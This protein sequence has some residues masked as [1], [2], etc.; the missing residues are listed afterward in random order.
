MI[1]KV[2]S[3]LNH[4]IILQKAVIL[5]EISLESEN[6]INELE[7]EAFSLTSTLADRA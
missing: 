5:A 6:T 3:N 2:P 7:I 4:S 1:L